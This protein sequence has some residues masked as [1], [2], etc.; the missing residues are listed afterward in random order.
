MKRNLHL[1]LIIGLVL[2]GF[3]GLFFSPRPENQTDPATL[4]GDGSLIDSPGVYLP[5]T[6]ALEN[7]LTGR[8]L[9]LDTPIL[10]GL[11]FLVWG[12]LFVC[13]VFGLRRQNRALLFLSLW[14]AVE[15]AGFFALSPFGLSRS[16]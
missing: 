10:A 3:W 9:R 12:A 1:F 16:L 13:L 2:L 5:E 7:P 6:L 14:M 8:A 4:A 11:G 15:L